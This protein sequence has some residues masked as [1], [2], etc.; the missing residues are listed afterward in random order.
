MASLVRAGWSGRSERWWLAGALAAGILLLGRVAPAD[1]IVDSEPIPEQS[2]PLDL[3]SLLTLPKSMQ[4]DIEKKGG[5]TR[6][7]WRER[8]VALRGELA[9]ERELL[10]S[11]KLSLE[12]AAS[13]ADAWTFSPAGIGNV[14][15]SPVDYK[16]REKIRHGEA[17]VARLEHGLRELE[18]E[19]NLAGVPE[20]WRR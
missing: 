11:A 14:T 10:E 16:L 3:D 19:A 2:G 15:D 5:A 9:R 20:D 13:G 4:Y 1:S 17:E 8:F 18:V 7:E 6:G 12:K